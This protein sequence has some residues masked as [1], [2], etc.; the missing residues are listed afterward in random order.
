MRLCEAY[1][2]QKKSSLG[3]TLMGISGLL[4]AGLT[5]FME[6]LVLGRGMKVGRLS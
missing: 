1:R 2:K 3:V 4:L 5:M 6:V